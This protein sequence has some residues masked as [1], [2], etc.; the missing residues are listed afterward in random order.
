MATGGAHGV[1]VCRPFQTRVAA[2]PL[3]CQA[4]LCP[5]LC[6]CMHMFALSFAPT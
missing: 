6:A 1:L 3:L 4:V 2:L 5:V